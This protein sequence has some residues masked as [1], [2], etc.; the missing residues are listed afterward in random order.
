[1][2]V[3]LANPPA[4]YDD[5]NRH[6]IQA[7]SRWSFSIFVSPGMKEHYL[8]YPF[9]EGYGLSILKQNG[10]ESVGIDACAFDMDKKEFVSKIVSSK[11]DLLVVD[12]PTISFPLT[13]PLLGEIRRQV[14]CKIAVA[15]GHITSLASETL[16]QHGVIDYALLGEYEFSLLNLAKEL[17]KGSPTSID[18]FDGVAFR[19]GDEVI[20]KR[21]SVQ[22]FN[23]DEMPYPD[24]KDYPIELYHDFEIAG[25]PCVQ[26]LTSLGCPYKCSF[27][28]PIRVMNQDSPLYRRRDPQ[29]I[30][31]EM[32]YAKDE[33]GAKQVYFDDDTFSVDKSR[34]REMSRVIRESQLDLPWTAMGDIT[35]DEETIRLMSNSG[36]AGIK[37]GVETASTATLDGIHKTFMKIEKV[38]QFVKWLRKYGIWSHSTF[39]IGLPG[40]K[41]EDILK[42]IEFSK[43]LDTDSVQFSIATPFPGTPFY[44]QAKQNGWLATDDW[45]QYDGANYAVLNYPDLSKGDIE[46][47][48]RLALKEWYR[49][50]VFKEIRHPRRIGRVIRA[51][52]VRY[53]IRKT[54]SHLHGTL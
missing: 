20:V 26:M 13:I 45:T 54:L 25:R 39:I 9:L 52:S 24:R 5:H 47:L 14:D 38:K 36:C 27:C 50:A 46:D 10:I 33:L 51:G 29:K 42:T 17:E 11:P 8:P 30:V 23:L 1:M 32:S 15:G 12:I 7:G 22:K 21:P 31:D 18:D 43:K 41:R 4:Y 37:F 34:L 3:V 40:D 35:I 6:F 19:K 28:M 44:E 2:K 53:S 49:N 48:H 16:K